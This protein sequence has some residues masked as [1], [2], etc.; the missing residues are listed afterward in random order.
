M[1]RYKI[2]KTIGDGTYGSVSKA[3]HKTTGEVVAIKQM[4]KK[5]R[6]WNECVTMREVRVLLNISH[7][8]VVRLLE[9]IKEDNYLALIFEFLDED[10][11]HHIK[12]RNKLLS[13][14]QIRNIKFLDEDVY[15]HI[16]DRNKLL[17]ETQIRNIIF[18]TLQGLA[19]MHA[20]GYFHRDLKPE[21]L[22]LK[23]GTVKIADFGLVRD[24]KVQPPCT[25]YVSTRWYRAPEV[26]LRSQNYGPSIDIFAVGA[27]MAELYTFKPLFPGSSEADQLIKV[28]KVMGT[29]RNWP[30]GLALAT[31]IGFRFPN[32]NGISLQNIIPNSSEAGIDLMRSM[33]QY[34]PESRPTALDA[35]RHPYF[36]SSLQI[37]RNIP[38]AGPQPALAVKATDANNFSRPKHEPKGEPRLSVYERIK[39]AK[40]SPGVNCKL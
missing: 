20:K 30:Q 9:V 23:S 14:T 8:N 35:L 18:Q 3:V 25:E 4:K 37:P 39:K 19:H 1:D 5:V 36:S 16:K 2:L 24:I 32:E 22:L 28:C 38:E 26:L 27:V 12:D 33:L 31:Q 34:N 6:N 15:H 10:V 17:S 7:P 29:P 11:Y 21:N 13:E 40:Y